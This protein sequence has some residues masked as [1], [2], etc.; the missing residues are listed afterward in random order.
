[1]AILPLLTRPKWGCRAVR[2]RSANAARTRFRRL[3]RGSRQSPDK[4]GTA[5]IILAMSD[6]D[7][8]AKTAV[9]DSGRAR[10][11]VL[12]AAGIVAAAVM[13]SRFVGLFREIVTRRYIGI[14]TLDAEAYA[15]ATPFPETIFLVVAAGA[16]GAA[17]IPTF[18]A[19]F[20]QDDDAGGWRLFSA[21][22][23]LMFVAMT[24]ICLVSIVFAPQILLFFNGDKFATEPDLLP[25]TVLLLRIMLISPIIFGV[26]GVVMGALQARQ[27]FLL[28]ALAPTVYN[29]AIIVCT[30]LFAWT[31]WGAVMGLAIGTVVGA[32]GHL[33][34]QIPAL[35][36]KQARY[37]AVLTVRDPGVL[38]VL[39]LMVPRVL[40][41]S[42]SQIN[43]FLLLLLTNTMMIGSLAALQTA[44]RL[45][46][47]PQGVI[48]QALAIAAFPT[49]A[50]LA[51]RKAFE[52]MRT[53]F[54]D[55]L[56]LLAYLGLPV[57]VLFMLVGRPIVEILF[58]RGLFDATATDLVTIALFFY[59]VGIVA[60]LAIEVINRTFYSLKDTLTPLLAGGLQVALMA[61]F[62]LWLRDVV[63]PARGWNPVG[64]PALGLSLSNVVEVAVL[65]WLL[66]RKM[67]S[68][69]G[70]SLANGVWRMGVAAVVMA[71]AM[72]G[73]LQFID[74]VATWLYLLAGTAVGAGS[75]LLVCGL[76]HV[77]EQSQ[78]LA[79]GM[80]LTRRVRG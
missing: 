15:I 55:S 77:K 37:T 76:L 65:L 38:Q 29:L 64:A 78:L 17:F 16:V 57:S 11:Q 70:R 46:I 42:F 14:E 56:R 69:H 33:L 43:I 4:V 32:I 75:Y 63:F 1:M 41:L 26:S 30:V 2:L 28:P 68:I 19:Y 74:P 73:V 47:M 49:L 10:T 25:L 23:N 61:L 8:E 40:G 35:R 51:A 54:A 34:I 79:Y 58:Q 3:R 20:E 12:R 36:W 45:I 27:H 71:V 9:P 80:R 5:G 53:I 50:S 62:S 59:S 22:V 60:L 44:F 24:L 6:V 21:V 13:L 31:R 52:E 66:R 67:G 48:G 72:L 18:A 39:R 7:S